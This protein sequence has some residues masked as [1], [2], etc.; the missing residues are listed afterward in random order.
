MKKVGIVGDNYSG[1]YTKTRTACR[2]IVTE[3]GLVLMSYEGATGQWMLPGGGLEDG[4]TPGECCR[5]EVAEET[6]ILIDPGECALEVTEYYEDWKG[7]S[8]YFPGRR[9]GTA[10]RKLTERERAAGM[11]PRWIPLEE[12]VEI[13]SHHA[14]WAGTDEMRRGLYLREYTALTALFPDAAKLKQEE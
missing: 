13:L 9:T 11:E 12:A 1:S 14:D 5:R 3:D 4:E 2:G 8:L 10:P 7:T 6:G